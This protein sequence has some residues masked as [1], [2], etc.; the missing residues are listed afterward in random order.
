MTRPDLQKIPAHLHEE[1][2]LVKQDNLKEAFFKH[3]DALSF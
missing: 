2:I 1:I 3:S